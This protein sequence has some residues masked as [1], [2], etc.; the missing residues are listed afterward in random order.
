MYPDVRTGSKVGAAVV[1]AIS[2]VAMTAATLVGQY[3]MTVNRDR[4]ANAQNEPQ[5]WLMMN[6]DYAST[7]IF[8]AH[9]DQSRECQRPEDGLGARAGRH[10]GRRT[11]R[12]RK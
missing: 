2:V 3:S 10:A 8:Q 9:A 1:G 11:E 6:G 12:S 5:N 7:Q 4:L